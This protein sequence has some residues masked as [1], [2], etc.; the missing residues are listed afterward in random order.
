MSGM[1]RKYSELMLN[2]VT[3]LQEVEEERER[4]E[5]GSDKGL[6]RQNC[7]AQEVQ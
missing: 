3:P 4:D 5:E 7:R 1:L 2:L 6:P